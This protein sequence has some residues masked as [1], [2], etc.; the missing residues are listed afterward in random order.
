M[1]V[2]NKKIYN[3]LVEIEDMLHSITE[4]IPRKQ[5]K[6]RFFEDWET[7][8]WQNCEFKKEVDEGGEFDFIC[9]KTNDVCDF[10][11]CPENE[12]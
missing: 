1:D 6:F 10:S 12:E 4:K 5:R 11:R 7:Q 8:I 9:K 2:S 3:K